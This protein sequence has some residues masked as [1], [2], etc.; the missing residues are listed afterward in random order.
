MIFYDCMWIYFHL[1][2]F[3]VNVLPGLENIH[4]REL[5]INFLVLQSQKTSFDFREHLP[6]RSCFNKISWQSVSCIWCLWS[7]VESGRVISMLS[8]TILV[9][10]LCQ[11]GGTTLSIEQD[12][13]VL[14]GT[15]WNVL[16][17]QPRPQSQ[18]MQKQCTLCAD[19]SRLLKYRFSPRE[20]AFSY[21]PFVY[22]L[23]GT[24]S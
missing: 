5:A 12:W 8:Y 15:E 7:K 9:W 20:F 4:D 10:V 1:Q 19:D 23:G 11:Q 18:D 21:F 16:E 24:I 13:V 2:V 17:W 3:N 22:S 14:R 6:N